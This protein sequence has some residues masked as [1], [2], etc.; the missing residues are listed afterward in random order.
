MLLS[1]RNPP[2]RALC[3]R[4]STADRRDPDV[5]VVAGEYG[6]VTPERRL[7]RDIPP[8]VSMKKTV[9]RAHYY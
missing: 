5:T 4:G 6:R 7:D 3:V 1:F 8:A 9:I 2:I